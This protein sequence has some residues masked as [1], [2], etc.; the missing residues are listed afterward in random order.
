MK[1]KL[2]L[3]IRIFHQKNMALMGHHIK[4]IVFRLG[5]LDSFYNLF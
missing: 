1:V 2:I 3:E 4:V 5:I